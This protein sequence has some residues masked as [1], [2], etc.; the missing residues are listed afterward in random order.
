MS[1]RHSVG[2]LLLA[3]SLEACVELVDGSRPR[4]A[5]TA[6]RTV[7]LDASDARRTDDGP[8]VGW[9]DLAALRPDRAVRDAP[10]V[11]WTR[12]HVDLVPNFA[13]DLD[14]RTYEIR[15]DTDGGMR[16]TAVRDLP[17]ADRI[18]VF[19]GRPCV[20][21][22][23]L[24]VYC[25]GPIP[26]TA[27]TVPTSDFD[28]M[29]PSGVFARMLTMGSISSISD[30]CLLY[31]SGSACRMSGRLYYWATGVEMVSSSFGTTC[32]RLQGGTV[33]CA[34]VNND[35]GIAPGLSVW[36]TS[37][38]QVVP[39]LRGAR[40]I[41]QDMGVGCA[42]FEDETVGCWGHSL[43]SDPGQASQCL[44]GGRPRPREG[45]P[46]NRSCTRGIERVP[47]IEDAIAVYIVG[48]ARQVSAC[49]LRRSGELWCW[50]RVGVVPPAFDPPA[51][52]VPWPFVDGGVTYGL[53]RPSRLVG[54][55]RV[56]DFA[57]GECAS[58]C[59]CVVRDDDSVWCFD[60]AG[61]RFPSVPTRVRWD[62]ESLPS[63]AGAPDDAARRDG[64]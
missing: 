48:P 50:G 30:T 2:A 47:G 44:W 39:E 60:G 10:P 40:Q 25:R 13:L 1:K 22:D 35:G 59:G 28:P 12:R 16:F 45:E 5:S 63:D 43:R 20:I 21:S 11:D 61:Q 4:D 19:W 55:T 3:S 62:R 27:L 46:V 29:V 37:R 54:L 36:L 58:Q 24:G 56:V 18:G 51:E 32:A 38:P 42:I 26:I 15:R 31:A 33:E 6:L 34:D 52:P 17:P 8:D 14:G 23:A 7:D 41:V 9:T 49:A 57:P 53:R 64:P